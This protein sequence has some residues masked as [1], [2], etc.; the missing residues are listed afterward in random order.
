MSGIVYGEKGERNH[1]PLEKSEFNYKDVLKVLKKNNISGQVI[2]ES[3]NLEQDAIL[4]KKFY[5][6]I[7]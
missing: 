4:M 1:L 3:P 5:T 2:C 6:S 7:T